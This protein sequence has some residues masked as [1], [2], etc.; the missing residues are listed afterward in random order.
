MTEMNE[1]FRFSKQNQLFPLIAK[2]AM[3]Q[4]GNDKIDVYRSQSPKLDLYF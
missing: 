1:I 2:L 3:N 4:P